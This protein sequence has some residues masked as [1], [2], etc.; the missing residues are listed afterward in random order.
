[1]IVIEALLILFSVALAGAAIGIVFL[2]IF[3]RWFRRGRRAMAKMTVWLLIMSAVV[4]AADV[5]MAIN[6]RNRMTPASVRVEL[7][8]R[9]GMWEVR[10]P[11][12]A[13]TTELHVP[14]GEPVTIASYG[15]T[16]VL[17]FPG[18]ALLGV[19]KHGHRAEWS[20]EVHQAQVVRGTTIVARHHPFVPLPIVAEPRADFDRWLAH[21]SQPASVP[22]A[23]DALRGRDVFFTARCAYCHFVRGIWERAE[24]AAPD[25]THL[26]SRRLV[27]GRLPNRKGYLS[28]WIV[29]PKSVDRGTTMPS[30]AMDPHA[31]SDLL[32]FLD[33]LK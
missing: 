9:S 24:E 23:P 29:D 13:A 26:A 31:L 11:G 14:V 4:V 7:F 12:G 25:L 28:G 2:A 21:E 20:M 3:E 15:D 1:M 30:N 10:Y 16:H 8:Q 27:A 19:G 5:V 18:T 32:A 6:L 33:T 17:W 22:A